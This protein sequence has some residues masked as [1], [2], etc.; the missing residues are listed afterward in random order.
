VANKAIVDAVREQVTAGV[1]GIREAVEATS[2]ELLEQARAGTLAVRQEGEAIARDRSRTEAQFAQLQ[3]ALDQ[4]G[5]GIT[6]SAS[7]LAE[8][9][10][11]AVRE[12]TEAAMSGIGIAVGTASREIAAAAREGLTEVQGEA[13]RTADARRQV[14][15]SGEVL[16]RAAAD[17]GIQ[18]QRLAE[19][20]EVAARANDATLSRFFAA[21]SREAETSES[22][23]GI[24]PTHVAEPGEVPDREER[25]G[26]EAVFPALSG[27][28]RLFRSSGTDER[29]G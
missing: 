23:I 19:A 2:A 5:S 18:G 8:G 7:R 6:R 29:R 10:N 25:S 28:R 20:I 24:S 9:V 22:V 15:R 26:I 27:A 13:D 3:E 1:T 4:L 16:E 11:E 17:L 21:V 14:E 12:Q